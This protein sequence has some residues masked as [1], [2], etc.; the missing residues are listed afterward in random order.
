MLPETLLPPGAVG[1]VL[2]L[3]LPWACVILNDSRRVIG[4]NAAAERLWGMPVEEVGGERVRD[5]LPL[6][7][8]R[9]E[10]PDPWEGLLQTREATRCLAVDRGGNA[11]LTTLQASPVE[12]QGRPLLLLTGVQGPAPEV[13]GTPPPWA[14]TDPVTGLGNRQRWEMELTGWGERA[15]VVIFF[16]LDA[17]KEINDLYGHPAGDRALA[18]TGAALRARAPRGALAVRY[19]GDELV[20]VWPEGEAAAAEALAAQVAAD[21]AGRSAD[22]PLSPR[23][24]FGV[25]EFT[26][27]ALQEAVRRAD[28]ALYERKGILLRAARGGRIILTREGRAA[29][30]RAGDD[31]EALALGFERD[32]DACFQTQYRR[33]L[34]QAREFVDFA[35]PAEGTAVVE[36]GAGSGRITFDGGL[37]A[38]VGARGQLLVTDPSGILLQVARGRA[39]AEGHPW[40]RFLR[41]P[42]EELPLASGTVDLA[43]GAI[44][45][46][47]SDGAR[48]LREMA[49]VVRPGGAVAISAGLA[50]PWPPVWEEA[51][52]P[53][54][55]TLARHGRAYRHFLHEPGEVEAW[56][57]G[58]GLRLERV[59]GGD[60][61]VSEWPDADTA[62]GFTRQIGMVRLLLRGLAEECVSAAREDFEARLRRG[63]ASVPVGQRTLRPRGLRLFA[64]RPG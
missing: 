48:A 36:V 54:F 38:R 59:A 46:H 16:D 25:A 41:A 28:D 33:A 62:I 20:L 34:E 53:V 23:L 10:D 42:A 22:M 5:V 40:V 19:G 8:E 1:E 37:A 7:P 26:P 3:G 18:L 13:A 35:A 11:H 55:E 58:A 64:R 49:R 57:T 44:F 45:L 39:V 50:F 4:M 32:F 31:R 24:S 56:C 6:L 63:F 61:E 30:R 27:G 12:H 2:Y 60:A 15:G 9:P 14:L 29:V 47:F 52:A 17:L 21:L 51:L 43:L